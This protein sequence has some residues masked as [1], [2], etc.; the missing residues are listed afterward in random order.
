MKGLILF[1]G[2]SF[3]LGCQGTRNRGDPISYTE[4]I[5]ACNSHISFINNIHAY[6]NADIKVY[7]STYTTQ[8]D[9]KLLDIYKKYLIG[10][11]IYDKLLG[12]QKLFRDT[13]QKVNL[14]YDLNYDFILYIRV[15]LF[16]KDYF[17]TIFNPYMKEISYPSICFI[18]HHKINEHPRVN[19][20]ML[21]IPNKYFKYLNILSIY[22]D[23]WFKAMS[24]LTY[25]DLGTMLYTYHDSD[26][27]KD[28]N[29]IYYIVNRPQTDKFHSEGLIFNKFNL[30]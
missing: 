28:Y 7:I 24:Y 17:T 5:K 20:T 13:I 22:H 1:L 16:L 10:Y 4:Q 19:D 14:N 9:S 2:E 29:P 3:R 30:L 6:N 12:L 25:H 27:E 15:D 11:T 21:F 26:S 18:P 8:Y 23:S